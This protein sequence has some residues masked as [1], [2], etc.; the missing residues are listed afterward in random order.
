M[1]GSYLY[2]LLNNQ[3]CQVDLF[4]RNPGTRCGLSPCAWGTSRGFP[5]LVQSSGLDP[6]KYLIKHF[7]YVVMDEYRIEADLTTVN[8]P[9]LVKDL[10]RGAEIKDSLINPTEYDRIID[11]TGISRAFLPAI[12]D[13]IILP[14]VQWRI[15][16]NTRLDNRIKLGGIGFAWSFPLS[17]NEYHV[18]CGSLL[19][20]PCRIMEELA[21]VR[22]AT[23]KGKGMTICSCAGDVRL[24]GP[25]Q[26]RPFVIDNGACDIWGVGEAIGCVA[27]LAGDGIV[28]GMRSAQILM[29]HWDDP[30]GYTQGILKAF[31]WMKLERSVIDRLKM[32]KRL[33]MND[34]WVLR[35]NSRRMGM[36]VGLREAHILLDHLGRQAHS[37]RISRTS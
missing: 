23:T 32:S 22:N 2:R 3:G 24:T 36:K 8:K 11:A 33:R 28:A 27:P 30:K 13:D 34:A 16:T 17:R 6:Q 35:R 5:E 25:Y 26:S 10:R 15:R 9:R 7:G 19:S 14:C 37:I 20:D 18:G 4:G 29:E 31:Q 1:A 12:Q 21:W